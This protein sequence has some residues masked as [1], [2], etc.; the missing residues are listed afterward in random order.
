MDGGEPP[1]KTPPRRRRDLERLRATHPLPSHG[2]R[3]D[4]LE[5][6]KVPRRPD[7]RRKTGVDVPSTPAIPVSPTREFAEDGRRSASC[8]RK[9]LLTITSL[10]AILSLRTNRLLLSCRFLRAIVSVLLLLRLVSLLSIFFHLL[11]LFSFFFFLL[12]SSFFPA[13]FLLFLE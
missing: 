12:F 13:L 7:Q 2:K 10:A 9:R 4:R 1:S 11:Y 8:C 6:F 3:T 5:Q